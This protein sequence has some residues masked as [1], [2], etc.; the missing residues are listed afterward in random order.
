MWPLCPPPHHV[1]VRYIDDA[2]RGHFLETTS[3]SHPAREQW[4]RKSFPI[5][6]RSVDSGIYL[7]ALSKREGITLMA[8]TVVEHLYGR[9]RYRGADRNL[10]D[11]PNHHPR[12]ISAILWIGT[13]SGK[14]LDQFR[15][16][17]PTPGTAP[18]QELRRAATMMKH[19]SYYFA[20][21]GKQLG[22]VPG[23]QEG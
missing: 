10:R 14:L 13:A 20:L 4:L 2:D 17:Y 7:R 16:R 18:M 23:V 19:N 15:E 6:D 8:S 1:L 12:D 21:A 9:G 5:N 3:G 11:D 22:W